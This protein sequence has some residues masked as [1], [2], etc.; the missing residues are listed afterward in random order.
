MP[1]WPHSS[2]KCAALSADFVEQDAVVG[3]DAD[4]IAPDAR[5]AGDDGRAVE[6]LELVELAVVDQPRDHL[7]H[8]V[9][10]A[11]VLWHDAVQLLGG[12]ARLDRR[13]QRGRRLLLPVEVGDDAPD[14]AERVAVVVGVMV[15]DARD[16][17]MDVGAAQILGADDLADR[18]LHQRR[19]G[20]E[21][22]ALLAH[23]DGLVAHRRHIGTAR[24]ARAHDAGDLRDALRRH[25]GLIVEDAA[26]MGLVRENLG[27]LRQVGAAGIDEID[28]RQPVL[29]RDFLCAE[30]LLHRH[31]I[32]GAALHR[33]VVA[34]D[35]AFDAAD[36]AHAG[37]HAR[38]RRVVVVHVH[39]RQ[40]RQLE[41]RRAGIEQRPHPLARQELAA[42]DMALARF[43][44]AAQPDRVGAGLEVGDQRAHRLGVALEGVGTGVDL[45]GKDGH[46]RVKLPGPRDRCKPAVSAYDEV[47]AS[48][49][50]S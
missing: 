44:A 23:D 39:R 42:R 16:A 2:M 35:D 43:L 41:E 19:A 38:A 18:G 25:V 12:I 24:G 29:H 31:R 32:I 26:E 17:G 45:R 28:A 10:R 21:D 9:G 6:M 14:H 48:P 4:R 46:V 27:P 30:M 50:S 34:H 3:D 47:I 8:V 20:Q 13:Q 37:D 5:E 1:R 33:G 11:V 40:R 22:R 36:P 15:G 49:L 7:A